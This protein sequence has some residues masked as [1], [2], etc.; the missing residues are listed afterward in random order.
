MFKNYLHTA[1]RNLKSSKF[2]S[3]IN[4]SG[5]A[6]GMATAIMLL[7]WVKDELSYDKFHT[8]Y[9]NIYRIAAHFKSGGKILSWEGVPGPMA[10]YAQ[11]MPKVHS[12][13]RIND[14][15][16]QI[17]ADRNRKKII[18][19]NHTAFVDST[20]FS[21]FDFKLL[22]G[23]QTH[24][25]PNNNSVVIT[26]TLA[27]KLFDTED[28]LGNVLSFRDNNFTIT[29]VLEDFPENSSL[30]FD[31]L[32]PMG[33]YAHAFTTGGGNGDWKTI[34]Q[35]LGNYAFQTYVMLQNG[36]DPVAIGRQF[37]SAYKNAR[38]G[39]SDAIFTLQNLAAIHLVGVD[40][41]DAAQKMVQ[42]F[43]LVAVLLLA[44]AA[45]NYVNLSTARSLIRAR[46]VS[47]RK[48]I[49]A[50]RPQLFFQFVMETLLLFCLATILAIIL[51]VIFMPLYNRLSGKTLHFSLTD[52]QVWSVIAWSVL[53]MLTASSVYPAILL[54]SFRPLEALKGKISSGVSTGLF[55]KMLVIFQFTI[56]VILII[57]TLVISNQ[58]KYVQQKDLGYDK[59]YV[60]TVPLNNQAVDHIDAVK[61]ELK[62]QAGILNV[63]LSGIPDLSDLEDASSDLEWP[64]KP[65]NNHIIIGQA[66]IDQDFI[67]T[68]KMQFVEGGNFSG[69]PADNT[70]YIVNQMAIQEMGLKPPYVGQSITFHDRR[71][72]IIGVVK[73]FNFKSLREQISPL[74]FFT[75][76]W[77]GSVLYVRTTAKDAPQAIAA[78]K[79]EYKKYASDLP[80]SY[81]FVDQQFDEKY[82]SDQRA[83]LLF[84]L[85]AAMAIF[86]SCL[87]LLGLATYTAQVRTKEIGIRKVLG[88][89]VGSLIQLLSKDFILLVLLAILL[90]VPTAWYGMNRWLE[91]FAYRTHISWWMFAIAGLI[92]IVI[93]LATISL[94]ATKAAIANPVD[95]LRTE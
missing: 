14:D 8:N 13:V 64:G 75:W 15:K 45:I 11:S 74:L 3:L 25:F 93:A 84:N 86:I 68:M 1:W 35:D 52:T 67:P 73:D 81:R 19:G 54:S 90:A 92:A 41:N 28:V 62:N 59:S 33:F 55:R 47:I 65:E 24:L 82:R 60:F 9:E 76:G 39:N 69:T 63:S 38:D 31:A 37:T 87:G 51:I 77:K 72:T 29:G 58:M 53:G 18:D 7:L 49:G 85:F 12:I 57:G 26:Q 70:H 50:N 2:Y 32:F 44:I 61:H 88:A 27:Q 22:K 36:S 34:D 20:F 23:D 43:L 83:G 71:G 40:G 95:N 42:I 16:G 21:I 48:I 46:E 10:V 17:L 89:S 78:V 5:L 80:F 94:Q 30:Q 91:D 56:S 66:I 6:I 4:I 79:K